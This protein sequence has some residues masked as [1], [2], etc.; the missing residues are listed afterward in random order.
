MSYLVLARKF[1]PQTFESIVGQE[2]ITKA[3]ANAIVRNRIPHAL[4]L[5]GPRGVGKTSAARVFAR[6]VNCTGRPV[7]AEA[8][9]EADTRRLVEPCGECPNCKEIA[10]SAS[11]SVWEIDGASN[12]SV[13]NVR[14]LIESLR[15]LP[16]PGSVYKIYIIDEVHMLS[17]SAFNALL[18]SLEEPPPN[19]LFIFA[20]TEPHKIPET[21]I[22]RCQR[23]DFHRLPVMVII[24]QLKLI[25][26]AEKIKVD[27][28]V[29]R[30]IA[31][32]AQG[33]MRDAQSMFDR[34]LAFSQQGLTLELAQKVF[35]FVDRGFFITLSEQIVAG[36]VPGCLLK[37]NEVFGQCVDIR[38]FAADFIAHFRNLL[39]LGFCRAAKDR[40]QQ[41]Q[42]VSMLE[43]Q[44]EEQ[45]L[46]DKVVEQVDLFQLQRLFEAAEETTQQAL[47]SQFPRFVYEAGVAKMATLQDLKPVAELIAELRSGGGAGPGSGSGPGGGGRPARRMPVQA[48][49]PTSAFSSGS[50]ASPAPAA[51]MRSVKPANIPAA[52]QPK[53]AVPAAEPAPGEP[54]TPSSLS[55]NP[56]WLEFITFARGR[57]AMALATYLKRVAPRS[58][59]AGRLE[60]EGT[61]FELSAL[62]DSAMAQSLRDCLAAYSGHTS[63]NISYQAHAHAPKADSPKS[64]L[65]GRNPVESKP[66][67]ST[68]GAGQ[69]AQNP[70][71]RQR[72][73]AGFV[74][75]SVAA[76]EAQIVQ[77]Q[78]V[79]MVRHAKTAPSVQDVLDVFSGSKIERITEIK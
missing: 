16:P 71:E 5:T 56:N 39:I 20:T 44:P 30:F 8:K 17:T 77:D 2:H 59:V 40:S 57:G 10:R 1:R 73:R 29:L 42:V 23:H 46:L 76:Q 61:E 79:E 34:L 54:E 45:R 11:L 3:L 14:E 6:A 12:N 18:K 31:L 75:G 50:G 55:F 69:S 74:P 52:D 22:S 21:V 25:A 37:L 66:R 38:S 32:K 41:E 60:I 9:D 15:S 43:L 4:L 65:A 78:R 49:S 68:A 58:F 19:T 35:G 63:W 24:D 51:E 7:P 72:E 13:D 47:I 28:S 70:A 48:E 64:Q 67:I 26:A 27:D 53:S 33:G 62:K 36:D